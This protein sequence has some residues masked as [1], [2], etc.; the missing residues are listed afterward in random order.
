MAGPAGGA[1]H[2]RRQRIGCLAMTL[3][4]LLAVPVPQPSEKALRYFRGDNLLWVVNVLWSLAVP[5]LWLLSGL[6]ARLRDWAR[7]RIR[8]WPLALCLFF[9]VYSLCNFALGLPLGWYEG[10]WREHAY[11]LS[12]QSFAR[13]LGEA[14]KAL[15]LAIGGGVL[16]LWL[17]YWLLR[18]SPR[19]WWLWSGLAAVPFF[20]CVL[21]VTPIWI[22]PLFNHFGPMHDKT[23]EAGIERLAAR[24]GIPGSRIFEVDKSADTTTVNAY[25]DGL[26]GTRRIVLWDTLLARLSPPQVMFV[27]GHEIGHYVLGH[28]W[29]GLAFYS[30]LVLLALYLVHR[31]AGAALAGFG[32]RFGLAELA[33]PASLPLLE[34]L[35]SAALLALTPAALAISRHLE[36]EAD[37][38][39]LEL[40]RDNQAAAMAFLR[41]QQTNLS[42][43]R[44]ERWYVLWRASHPPLGERIDFANRYHPWDEGKPLRYQHLFAGGAA[45]GGGLAADLPAA[46]GRASPPA[47]ARDIVARI[48][49]A[50]G[51]SDTSGAACRRPRHRGRG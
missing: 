31:A 45:G 36:H 28:L 37:R 9:V 4:L 21:F 34:L 17:P 38:F 51:V 6:S 40:T 50:A 3:A 43:P 44:P 42:V 35:L 29:Q 16:T 1:W 18:R 12:N 10:F 14:A 32:Q 24:A 13:W 27:T 19:R 49:G 46:A 39:G 8:R 30:A 20:F 25:V 47:T 26:A 15:A 41:M 7:R 2:G 23:L 33:D 22:E 48:G 11:G 5:A